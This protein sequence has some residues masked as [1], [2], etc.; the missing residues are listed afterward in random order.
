MGSIYQLKNGTWRLRFSHGG[1][2]KE[3]QAPNKRAA[4][5][6]RWRKLRLLDAGVDIWSAERRQGRRSP[7]MGMHPPEVVQPGSLSAW[8][9][10]WLQTVALAHPR[11]LPM[12]RQ[13]LAHL[14]PELG[15]VQLTDLGSR[16]IRPALTR[17][18][19][20]GMSPP[21]LRHVFT[22]LSTALN[23]AVAD[24]RIP[25]NPCR[26]IATPKKPHFE[27]KTL[28]TEQ[29]QRLIDVAWDTRMGPLLAV[30]LSTGMRL[31]ELMALTWA[32]VDLAS[33]RIRVN[34]SVQ[35][36]PRGLHT[37]GS[38]KTRSGRREVLVLGRALT[39]LVEQ[40]ARTLDK[41][42][43]SVDLVF[44]ARDGGYWSMQGRATVYF[45][46]LLT[47]ADCPRIR[48]HDLRHTAG[49]FLTRSVGVVV[50][51]RILGH[52]DPSITARYYGHAQPED[53]TA[54]ARAISVL[55]GGG[56][57]CDV[58]AE[59]APT[60]PRTIETTREGERARGSEMRAIQC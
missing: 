38:T 45:Q 22:A 17:L 58:N 60:A 21:M 36:N 31:G 19:D 26:G 43:T 16:D 5:T 57:T 41:L 55:I 23:G 10:E 47:Q 2:I 8:F 20:A 12:Y 40:R 30:A 42:D 35:W 32:D 37:V 51:S 29:A 25:G 9:D 6:L 28:T 39:A 11:S 1:R 27:A 59:S 34:K 13:K 18:A 49:L 7:S 33:G 56:P 4:E 54:A 46:A 48:F 44:P 50:A 3:W 53:F 24:E 52:A 14:R 15:S